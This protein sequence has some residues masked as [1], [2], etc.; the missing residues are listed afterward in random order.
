[1][2]V[3]AE[4]KCPAC[5]ST[6][7]SSL[8]YCTKDGQP[9]IASDPLIGQVL[10]ERYRIEAVL[11]RGGMGVVYKATHIHID[12]EYAVKVL[13]PELVSNQSAIERFR[14]EARAAGRIRHPNAIQVT[15]FGITTER[16]VYLVMELIDGISLRKLL[17]EE[18]Y[19]DLR[20]AAHILSQTC[21]AV[22]AAHQSGVIHRDLK[23]DNI[24]IT[25]AGAD[26]CVKVLDFG[27]AKLRDTSPLA[28][29]LAPLTQ[30]GML[31][32]TPEYMSP[33]QCRGQLLDP[34]SDV[35]SLGIILY[36][37]L[38]GELPF[39]AFGTMEMVIKHL[40][41]QARPLREIV[42][43]TP[44]G[45]ERV[46]LRALEKDPARRQSS[47][48]E[49]SAEFNAALEAALKVTPG[50]DQSTALLGEQPVSPEPRKTVVVDHP[51]AFT[52]SAPVARKVAG[53]AP[54]KPRKLNPLVLALAGAL[55]VAVIGFGAYT[56]FKPDPPTPTPTP[57]A[58]TPSPPPG[59][60][61]IPGGKF[62][63][64]QPDGPEDERPA[65]MVEVRPFYIDQHEVTNEAY[66]KFT[67]AT[68]HRLPEHWSEGTYPRGSAALPVTHVTWQDAADYAKW[69]GK[70]LP[71]EE[72]WE[73][74]ARGGEKGLRYPW[75]NEWRDGF[76]NVRR[77]SG[78]TL[79]PVGSFR[80]DRSPFGDV[81]DL[82]GNVSEWV[83]DSYRNGYDARP[84]HNFKV[85][86]GGN[87]AERQPITNTSRLFD[88]P[89]LPEDAEQKAEYV[90]ITMPKVGFRCAKDI[91]R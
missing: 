89:D 20:R 59:M 70:R 10:D 31:I 49:L 65:H 40:N 27:I 66:Q 25:R 5:G 45:V 18:K 58:T 91:D 35:Y 47:A 1:M 55:L 82:A 54:P 6:Y 23:P 83:E 85:I 80:M 39:N 72:E 61:L 88:Y 14:I 8:L 12:T 84:D 11:G 62:S 90:K 77:P 60:V 16:I 68:K 79:A 24:I 86:R 32:G 19:F 4:K 75:G 57:A 21:G 76:A 33:E 43:S 50:P 63:M 3:Q 41:E 67:N 13:N 17:E 2:N 36:E 44:E 81:Y 38:C 34:R 64:G 71:R 28:Q 74:V 48:L 22:E 46:V 52:P 69:A 78:S 51:A 29:P 87:I 42:A 53:A 7:D 15:D 30:A 56:A 37:M 73:Y 9:L 26:E